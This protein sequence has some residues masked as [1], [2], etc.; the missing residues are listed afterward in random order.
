MGH[1]D[2]LKIRQHVRVCAQ[3]VVVAGETEIVPTWMQRVELL[4]P[5]GEFRAALKGSH[6]CEVMAVISID[7]RNT[8]IFFGKMECWNGLQ[9]SHI[10]YG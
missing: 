6:E 10:F 2:T 7:R 9:T 3:T 1:A 5:S 4:R 8:L